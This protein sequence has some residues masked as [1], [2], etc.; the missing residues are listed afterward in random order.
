M[1]LDPCAKVGCDFYSKCF[2]KQDRS[3]ECVCPVC[4]DQY[5]PVCG[6]DGKTYAN[7]CLMKSESCKM[8]KNIKLTKQSACGKISFSV[9]TFV[10]AVRT[11]IVAKGTSW[12]IFR[13]INDQHH[14]YLISI[15][16][17]LLGTFSFK[18]RPIFL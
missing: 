18:H 9:S 17:L 5:S 12:I 15:K 2:A 8:K 4:D 16:L 7:E 6:S 13:T 14:T 3:T 1:F 11:K 10:N